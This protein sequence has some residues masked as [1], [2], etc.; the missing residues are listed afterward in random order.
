MI[1]RRHRRWP[2]GLV[3]SGHHAARC[4]A[5]GKLYGSRARKVESDFASL[6]AYLQQG[7]G[8]ALEDIYVL[9]GLAL[10][11]QRDAFSVKAAVDGVLGDGSSVGVNA[12][13]ALAC[14]F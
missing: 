14:R 3:R 8:L 4:S 1:H 12:Q 10:M 13:V 7:P 5:G 2:V 11:A 9:R 6:D